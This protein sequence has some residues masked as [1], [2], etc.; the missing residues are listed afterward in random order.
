MRWLG[1][2]ANSVEMSLSKLGETVEDREAWHAAVKGP[3]RV[4]HHTATEQ[5][6]VKAGTQLPHKTQENYHVRAA[7]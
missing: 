7:R 1:S 3:Q 5:Q 2:L 6:L 4:R